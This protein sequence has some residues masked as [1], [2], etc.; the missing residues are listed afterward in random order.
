MCEQKVMD[1]A[2]DKVLYEALHAWAIRLCICAGE[3][4][5]AGERFWQELMS[6]KD[7]LEEFAY[8]YEHRDFLCA[9]EREGLTIADILVWQ[10]DHFKAHM[11]YAD[12]ANRYDKDRL[13]L[14][15]FRTLIELKKEP[16]RVA[17]AFASETGTDSIGLSNLP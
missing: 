10:T 7:I 15:V 12:S 4:E 16:L 13:L 1:A 11:D 17:R 8:Y 14:S 5:I 9:F 3:T 2:S 6:E